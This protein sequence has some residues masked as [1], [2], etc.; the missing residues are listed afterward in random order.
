MNLNQDLDNLILSFLNYY[1]LS[2]IISTNKKINELCEIILKKYLDK[3][4]KIQNFYKNKYIDWET[5]ED[6]SVCTNKI[7]LIRYY[8]KYYDTETFLNYPMFV[9]NKLNRPVLRQYIYNNS[10][11]KKSDVIKFLLLDNITLSDIN[12]VGW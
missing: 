4:K 10:I 8:I 2:K 9:T 1:D 7:S 12:Y 3:I 5:I 6:A 11:N